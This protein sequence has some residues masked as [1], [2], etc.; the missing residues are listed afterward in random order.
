LPEQVLSGAALPAVE[1]VKVS[2]DPS[3][4][5]SLP[6][7]PTR[8]FVLKGEEQLAQRIQAMS[9]GDYIQE[10]MGLAAQ[11]KQARASYEAT[12]KNYNGLALTMRIQKLQNKDARATET[13]LQRM[14]DTLTRLADQYDAAREKLAQIKRLRGRV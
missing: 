13:Q 2:T 5:E 10:A 6:D 11:A 12:L 4:L 14:Q 7:A 8:P 9:K 1:P 3:D